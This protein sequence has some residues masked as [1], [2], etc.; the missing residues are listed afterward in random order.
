MKEIDRVRNYDKFPDAQSASKA[1]AYPP[2]SGANDIPAYPIVLKEQNGS[3][4]LL[5]VVG[6][7]LRVLWPVVTKFFPWLGWL[8]VVVYLIIEWLSKQ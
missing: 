5:R 6:L 3:R 1:A 8:S 7:G 4:I 2:Q